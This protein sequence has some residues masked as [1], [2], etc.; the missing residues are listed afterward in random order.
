MFCA[1]LYMFERKSTGTEKF[2]F[3]YQEN[4]NPVM[5]EN[6][7]RVWLVNK[8]RGGYVVVFLQTFSLGRV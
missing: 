1:V 4:G 6:T 2:I 5:S 7:R 8:D 3:S